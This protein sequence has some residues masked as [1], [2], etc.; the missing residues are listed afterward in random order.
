MVRRALEGLDGV[1]KAKVSFTR[2]EARVTYDP[3]KVSVEQM[4]AA[5]QR[6]GFG[7]SMP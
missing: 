3:K 7:A 4:I 5:V 1:K 2:G 6:A